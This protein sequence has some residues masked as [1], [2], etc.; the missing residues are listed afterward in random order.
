ML[1]ISS[2]IGLKIF[3]GLFEIQGRGAGAGVG[4][5]DRKIE[6]VFGGVEIDEQIVDFIEHLGDARVGP[7]DFVDADDRR[8]FGLQRL[9][10]DE[11]GLRQRPFRGINQQHDAVDHR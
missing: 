10:Q 4:I 11:A 6:L 7:V 2:N 8:E 5:Y 3:T 1:T 9:F